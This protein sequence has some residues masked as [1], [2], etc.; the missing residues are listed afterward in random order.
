LDLIR[1]ERVAL[2]VVQIDTGGATVVT[3]T[4]T[5]FEHVGDT[6]EVRQQDAAVGVNRE[7]SEPASPD[8]I[9]FNEDH[10]AVTDQ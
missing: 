10:S 9:P 8:I 5:L 7:L 1:D 4:G 2:S 3:V 6:M